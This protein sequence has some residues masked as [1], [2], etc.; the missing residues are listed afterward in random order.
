MGRLAP[1]L[2]KCCRQAWRI[3]IRKKKILN[4]ESVTC[5]EGMEGSPGLRQ[6]Q[7]LHEPKHDLFIHTSEK[8]DSLLELNADIV[9]EIHPGNHSGIFMVK[10]TN[11]TCLCEGNN[12][13]KFFIWSI[14]DNFFIQKITCCK[15]YSPEQFLSNNIFKVLNRNL[16]ILGNEKYRKTV[17]RSPILFNSDIMKKIR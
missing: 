3:G 15:V 16:D 8:W 4:W 2:T 13:Q 9:I 11:Y 12:L 17:L 5:R 7:T 6:H 1:R 14:K 10:E